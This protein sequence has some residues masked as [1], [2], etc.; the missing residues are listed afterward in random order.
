MDL[1]T[2]DRRSGRG[3]TAA[4]AVRLPV[5][6]PLRGVAA[7][8][9]GPQVI[10]R[11]VERIE[12]AVISRADLFVITD[13]M[14]L[15]QHAGASPRQVVELPNV[16]MWSPEPQPFS[17]A[18]WSSATSGPWCRTGRWT[19]HRRHDRADGRARGCALSWAGS[20]R[21]RTTSVVARPRYPNVTFLGWVPDDELMSTMGGFDVFV[22]IEDPDHPAYRWVSPNKVFESMALGRP[23]V[24]A[25]GHPGRRARRR[26]RPRPG[27]LLRRCR[28]PAIR[29]VASAAR[30]PT[31]GATRRPGTRQ[32]RREL[33]TS[34]RG[35]ACPRRLP[36]VT[37]AWRHRGRTKRR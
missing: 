33:V 1:D 26:V 27:C 17:T 15:P 36:V 31:D 19:L 34:C 14:R 28:G 37:T 9:A 24:V 21:S 35:Y 30:P 8:A 18:G 3:A 25:E 16:P 5:P 2:G 23:I 12:N 10:A 32:L 7:R 11:A 20:A 29:R 4:G 13:L 22:Q 6:R